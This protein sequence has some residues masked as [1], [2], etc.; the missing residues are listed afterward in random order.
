MSSRSES[1]KSASE[2]FL[3]SSAFVTT[4]E[5]LVAIYDEYLAV[6]I[7]DLGDKDANAVINA[8]TV[9]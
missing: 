9:H 2:S 5:Y 6:R 1:G 8:L 7:R 4:S 3:P